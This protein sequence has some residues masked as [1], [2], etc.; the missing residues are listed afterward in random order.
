MP[1]L[2]GGDPGQGCGHSLLH[3]RPFGGGGGG[4]TDDGPVAR[5]TKRKTRRRER[6]RPGQ[7]FRAVGEEGTEGGRRRNGCESG[8]RICPWERHAP[9]PEAAATSPP[10]A[11]PLRQRC[12]QASPFPPPP[13]PPPSASPPKGNGVGAGVAPGQREDSPPDRNLPVRWPWRRRRRGWLTHFN[14]GSR[15]QEGQAVA[16]AEKEREGGVEGEGERGRRD[17]VQA[18][19]RVAHAGAAEAVL[20]GVRGASI[21]IFEEEARGLRGHSRE[22]RTGQD[23]HNS[24]VADL[25]TTCCLCLLDQERWF[26]SYGV[27][28]YPEHFI[29]TVSYFFPTAQQ[30]FGNHSSVRVAYPPGCTWAGAIHRS[31]AAATF[32]PPSTQSPNNSRSVALDSPL[33]CLIGCQPQVPPQSC[34][35]SRVCGPIAHGMHDNCSPG[36]PFCTL[37]PTSGVSARNA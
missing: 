37:P 6:R 16:V 8:G 25:D 35:N 4:G 10:R 30:A 33:V 31:Q 2:G 3:D 14:V 24:S 11:P 9:T 28:Q 36:S 7:R 18:Q 12:S 23:P 20:P 21:V 15:W 32:R 19:I 13:P 27:S 34:R 22:S 17:A 26:V 5:W 29:T 1:S